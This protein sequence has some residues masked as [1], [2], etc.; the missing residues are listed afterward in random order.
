MCQK[1]SEAEEMYK[2]GCTYA[3]QP[4]LTS[5]HDMMQILHEEMVTDPN[6]EPRTPKS[7]T[8]EPR[9]PEPWNPRNPEP[10]SPKPY[11]LGLHP[12]L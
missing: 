3:Q 12:T 10:R 9:T 5:A 2:A 7:Q 1:N 11:S 6:P 8:P 4:L